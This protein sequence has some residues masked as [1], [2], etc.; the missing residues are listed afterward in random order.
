MGDASE[1][2]RSWM[3][4]H[5]AVEKRMNGEVSEK[6]C[7]WDAAQASRA[8]VVETFIV[9]VVMAAVVVVV[10]GGRCRELVASAFR[11]GG[12]VGWRLCL[13]RAKLPKPPAQ[14]ACCRSLQ[15]TAEWGGEA[16]QK[17]R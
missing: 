9:G 14:G 16:W 2:G 3:G 17:P 8:A 12:L 11:G 1:G 7:A 15:Q 10:M 13:G 5:L 4:T 6:A